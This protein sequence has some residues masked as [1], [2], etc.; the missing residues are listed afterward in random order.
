[1]SRLILNIRAT[2]GTPDEAFNKHYLQAVIYSQLGAQGNTDY[3][4]GNRFRFFTFS[5][6]FPS[7][8]MKKGD[9]KKVIIS[10]P[11][12]KLI[13][14]LSKGFSE[15]SE[16]YLG[17]NKFIVSTVKTLR[18]NFTSHAYISGSP[19]VLYTDNLKNR[20]FSLRDGDAISFFM[21]RIKENAIKKYKQFTG[22]SPRY[23]DGPM[24][25]SIRLKKEVSVKL[26]HRGGDFYI[27]GTLWEKLGIFE[28][29]KIDY[30]FYKFIAECGIGEKNSL[31]F[32]FLNPLT[33]E[34]QNVAL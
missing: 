27:I 21:E 11:D 2:D 34:K 12:S 26:V 1:M 22:K 10:S 31:G 19:V 7:G 9:T 29:R 18:L 32:G 3:H 8:S 24:F 17:N 25:D 4:E 16:L 14:L 5:D 23:I 6:F 13:G 20:F 30:D 15:Y 33:E 28:G